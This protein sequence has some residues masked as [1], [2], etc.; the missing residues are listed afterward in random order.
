MS[1]FRTALRHS[2][3]MNFNWTRAIITSHTK[4]PIHFRYYSLKQRRLC[5]SSTRFSSYFFF[6]PESKPQQIRDSC[7]ALLILRA[8]VVF[9]RIGHRQG[10]AASSSTSSQQHRSS[11]AKTTT[12]KLQTQPPNDCWEL[13]E[14]NRSKQ[15]PSQLRYSYFKNW[16]CMA[17]YRYT[18]PDG[19]CSN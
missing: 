17:I 1:P 4:W 15:F 11:H 18:A 7:Y 6:C 13:Y 2:Y 14:G 8:A 19:L 9:G 12:Q 16:Y 10:A 3:N 5:M